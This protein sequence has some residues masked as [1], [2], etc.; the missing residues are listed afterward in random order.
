MRVDEARDDRAAV[1]V[2]AVI[3]G[4]RLGRGTEPHEPVGV[5]D[6]GRVLEHAAFGIVGHEFT[7]VG[8]EDGGHGVSHSG[9]MAPSEQLP[10]VAEPVM[11]TADHDGAVDDDGVDVGCGRGEG[12]LVG[13]DACSAY[14][15][16]ADRDQVGARADFEP[17]GVRP[18]DA[19][20]RGHRG[21]QFV[22]GESAALQ[23]DQ[24]LVEFEPTGFLEKVDDRVL[25]A[26]EAE[27][28]AGVGQRACRP[29]PVGEVALGRRAHAH[30]GSRRAEL[31][32]VR[33]GQMRRVHGGGAVAPHAGIGEQRSGRSA[34]R[35]HARLVLG[36]LLGQMDV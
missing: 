26:A 18:A 6:H 33:L 25:V 31:R 11:P 36:G 22:G 35:R 17:A 14:R 2:D 28:A 29:D 34:V 15:I 30:R 16:Q 21:V 4:R 7:D 1:D 5:G 13:V 23:G 3:G 20:V 10:D 19:G 27:G 32:D 8:D 24:P 9:S 12:D